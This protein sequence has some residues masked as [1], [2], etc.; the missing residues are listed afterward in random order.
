MPDELMMPSSG[1]PIRKYFIAP[2]QTVRSF[3]ALRDGEYRL[4]SKV[5]EVKGL[6]YN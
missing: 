4:M 2:D 5:N 3:A 6:T 1:E